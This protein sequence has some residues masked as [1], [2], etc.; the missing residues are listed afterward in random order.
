[1]THF[2]HE[3][4][5]FTLYGSWY[6]DQRR[7][8]LAVLPTRMTE[9]SLPLVILVDDAW[10]WNPDDPDAQPANNRRQIG[11]FFY[12]NRISDPN[13]FTAMNVVSLIHS[14]LGDLLFIPPKPT[15]RV[16]VADALRTDESGKVIHMEVS[17]NV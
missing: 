5:E 17:R 1:M 6:G 12:V 9:G 15:N 8:C 13:G 16:V 3:L 14:R 2:V 7:P 10:K 4:G 11:Q